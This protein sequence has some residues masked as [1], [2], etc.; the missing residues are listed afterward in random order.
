MKSVLLLL[1]TLLLSQFDQRSFAVLGGSSVPK[2]SYFLHS[3][4][5][6]IVYCA[7]LSPLKYLALNSIEALKFSKLL[8]KS[9]TIFF[10]HVSCC[11]SPAL[12]IFIP[13]AMFFSEERAPSKLPKH[14]KF[15]YMGLRMRIKKRCA[16][17]GFCL[18]ASKMSPREDN[19]FH[20]TQTMTC[21]NMKVS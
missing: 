17:V 10:V 12:C 18:P 1:S 6:N 4:F 8:I 21:P 3:F 13:S 2:L 14:R 9:S 19:F 7:C 5:C 20:I 15:V 16:F 11:F